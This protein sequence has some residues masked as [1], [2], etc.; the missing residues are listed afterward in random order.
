LHQLERRRRDI[1]HAQHLIARRR[2]LRRR[3]ALPVHGIAE[4][5][6]MHPPASRLEERH[7]LMRHIGPHRRAADLPSPAR[8]RPARI[9]AFHTRRQPR[10]VGCPLRPAA[11]SECQRQRQPHFMERA[12][13]N[14]APRRA[15]RAIALAIPFG[16]GAAPVSPEGA[17]P[18]HPRN[19]LSTASSASVAAIRRVNLSNSASLLR[20]TRASSASAAPTAFSSR[21]SSTSAVAWTR[22]SISS[23][24]SSSLIVMAPL[25][26]LNTLHSTS[27]KTAPADASRIENSASSSCAP[28]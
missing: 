8:R 2:G 9:A 5:E 23:G 10:H 17:P 7:Q 14:R 28:L 22:S 26:M 18:V 3:T 13:A 6:A 1:A 24:I 19:T 15:A 16:E 20:I 27:N 11:A 21:R 25:L 4:P 12:H